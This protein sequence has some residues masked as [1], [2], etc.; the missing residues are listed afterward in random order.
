MNFFSKNPRFYRQT[1]EVKVKKMRWHH[2]LVALRKHEKVYC[3]AWRK[4]SKGSGVRCVYVNTQKSTRW[5]ADSSRLFP[6]FVNKMSVEELQKRVKELEE[7]LRKVKH[8]GTAPREKISQM[9]GE[10]VDTNPYRLVWG[11]SGQLEIPYLY[12]ALLFCSYTSCS[13]IE[14]MV[15]NADS[16]HYSRCLIR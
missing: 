11:V 10:V 4:W 2:H 7:E 5:T 6:W 15:F 14:N 13:I 1:I 9:S 16:N 12:T 8:G 3:S